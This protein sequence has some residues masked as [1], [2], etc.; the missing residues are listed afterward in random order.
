M[1]LI[2][3]ALKYEKLGWFVLPI[4]PKKKQPIVKWAHRKNKRPS[5]DEIKDWFQQRPGARVGMATGAPSEI[6]VVDL[7]GPHAQER[8]E[9][10]YG[11]PE[12]IRADTGRVDGGVHLFF[13]YSGNGLRCHTGKDENKGIDL[14][15]DGGIVV[16]AP[17]PHKSGKNYQW[18]NINPIEDGLDD[19]LKMPSEVIEHFKK[20]N[21]G[22]TERKPITLEPVENGTRNDTLTRLVGKWISQ[23]LDRQTVFLTA[24][25]WFYSLPDKTDFE[26]K[27]VERTVESVFRTHERNH[28]RGVRVQ[29]EK[30]LAFPTPVMTGAGGYFTNVYGGVVEAPAHFLFMGYLTCL[31]AAVAPRLTLSSV[32]N[33]QPRLFTILL[34]ESASERKSTTL[35]I[36]IRHF[37]SVLKQDFNTCWGVGSAEGLQKILKK[38]NEFEQTLGT[39]L[40]F[41]ELKAFV[42]KCNIESSV[43]LPI[44]NTLFESNLY[45]SHTKKQDINIENAHLSMLA[46]TTIA[47]YERIYNSAFLDIGFPNRVFLIPGTAK[48]QHSIPSIIA[49]SD[50]EAMNKNLL[51]VLRHVG[52][53][54]ELDIAPDARATYHD[55]YMNLESSVHSKRLDTYSLRLMM[56]LAINNLKSEIDLETVEQATALCDWQLDIRKTHD[57]IDADNKSAKMEEAIRRALRRGPCKDYELK[58]KTNANR[59]GLWI[60]DMAVKNLRKANEVGWDKKGKKW[61]PIQNS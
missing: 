32:L 56:L 9:A 44:V 43:L 26:P 46:A 22:N 36:V 14:K 21:G 10:L 45:E 58:Q 25:G 15:T 3:D 38:R 13:K 55:W 27:E 35:N 28:L 23:G 5:R 7:D 42:S 57:P 59:L 12:T 4:D 53:G 54:M 30:S 24:M 52:D 31:G 2:E 48:R 51:Q 1:S 20:Q 41:D 18:V 39:L 49:Q 33:T 29:D 40:S 37:K 8:F 47:T 50:N 17:S 61:V 6:D 60:Y 16:L 19:L 11:T 34:G